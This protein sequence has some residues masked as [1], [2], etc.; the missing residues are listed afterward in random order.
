MDTFVC[1]SWYELRYLD[2]DNDENPFT[3]EAAEKWLPVD[4]YIGGIEHATG[5][6]LYFRFIAKVLSDMGYLPVD[7]PAVKL[8]NHGMV[9]DENGDVMSKSRGNV[10]SPVKIIERHGVDVSR[11]AMLFMAPPGNEIDWSEEGTRG[12][13]RFLTRLDRLIPERLDPSRA[14]DSIE[15]LS[16]RD[17][18][19]YRELNR[20]V[21]SVT[22]DIEEMAY[23]TAIARMMEFLNVVSDEDMKDSEIAFLIADKLVRILAPFA[24]HLAEELNRRLGYED[25]VVNRD[26]PDYDESVI[27]LETVEIG[28]QVNGR[29]RGTINI[30]PEAGREE[31]LSAAKDEENVLRH[32]EGKELVKVIYVPGRILNLIVK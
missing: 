11:T 19:L 25:F 15:G 5:H 32:L 17:A 7:E 20:T 3:A 4:L 21:K 16:E 27:A 28:V 10:V 14:A 12:T 8:F 23:N 13:R 1:S 30:A 24:P 9:C 31:A 18:E 29:L 26:W 22:E 6:L 2:P